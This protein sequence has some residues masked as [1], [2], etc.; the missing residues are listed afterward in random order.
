M[1][2][3][4]FLS[5]TPIALGLIVICIV[6]GIVT[7]KTALGNEKSLF[8]PGVILWACSFILT[9]S[10]MSVLI[11]AGFDLFPDFII[12]ALRFAVEKTKK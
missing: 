5:Q 7:A 2:P 6:A 11:N 3:G 9:W 4:Q 12:D 1:S 8:G 10:V